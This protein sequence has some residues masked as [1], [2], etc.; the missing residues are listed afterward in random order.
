MLSIVA[1]VSLL[2]AQELTLR[3]KN[4]AAFERPLET[5]EIP[6]RTLSVAMNLGKNES[7][8]VLDHGRQCV[9]QTIDTDGD[10]TLDVMLFQSAF[11]ASEEKH[12]LVRKVSQQLFDSSA[13]DVKYILPRKDVA[14]ENDRI[15]YRIYGGPL[16]GDV[17]DGL[18][19][20]VKRVRS[21]IIDKWYAGDSLKGE[22]RIS[23]HV[24]HGEGADFF[25]VGKSLGAGGCALWK[26]GALHQSGFFTGYSIIA[27]GPI[28]AIFMVSYVGDSTDGKP[29]TEERTYNLDAGE[30]LNRIETKYSN[31]PEDGPVLVA[32]GLVKRRNT[33]RFANEKQ[34]WLSL[35]GPT[36]DDSANGNL[37]T[38]IV[39]PVSSFREMKENKEHYLAIGV[40]SPDKRL[41]YYAGAGWTR[42]GDFPTANTWNSYLALFAE[43]LKYPLQIDLIT[44]KDIK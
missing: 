8:G 2:E 4:P 24:D 42:S 32:A 1:S 12:F 29:F 36:N 15:A 14:W 41:V 43:R 23:Y 19:V 9:V 18:D 16:A 11:D 5:V 30:N 10:G 25:S 38:G 3:V 37:G 28:R 35:W 34:G 20:W 17:L 22:K 21:H 40:T 27:S 39:M 6:W 7:V 44:K 26:E 33:L 13:T 31:L